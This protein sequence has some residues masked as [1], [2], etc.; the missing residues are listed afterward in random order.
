MTEQHQIEFLGLILLG[1]VARL[2]LLGQASSR[3]AIAVA[4]PGWSVRPVENTEWI[5]STEPDPIGK[6]QDA[7]ERGGL[8]FA[9]LFLDNAPGPPHVLTDCDFCPW[10]QN[11]EGIERYLTAVAQHFA[12]GAAPEREIPLQDGRHSAGGG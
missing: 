11:L 5:P 8:P 12:A 9:V 10:A 3:A 6:L 2:K 4:L 7:I 1:L